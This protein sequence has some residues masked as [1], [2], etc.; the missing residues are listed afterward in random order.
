MRIGICDDDIGCCALLEK[1]LL[2]YGIKENLDIQVNLYYSAESLLQDI[3][4]GYCYEVLFLDIELPGKSGTDLGNEFRY[5]MKNEEIEIVFI[6][7]KPQYYK[8]LFQ[9]SPLNFH[10]KPL[11]KKDI[12]KDMGRIVHRNKIKKRA[13]IYEAGGLC[14]MIYF[15]DIMYIESQRNMAVVVTCDGKTIKIRETLTSLLNKHEKTGICQCH[16]SYLVN[17]FYVNRLMKRTLFLK[18]GTKIPVGRVY[19]EN[20]RREWAEY[21]LV[22]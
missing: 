18:D 19:V 1:W 2:S 7:G 3:H 8:E 14:K 17:L 12:E 20:V 9:S 13:L 16:R 15:R 10:D 22:G 21:N 5:H 6:S 11:V 4:N